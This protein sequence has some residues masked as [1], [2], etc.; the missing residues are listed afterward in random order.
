MPIN[1]TMSELEGCG[2]E[3]EDACTEASR[4]EPEATLFG[5]D[6]MNMKPLVVV[7]TQEMNWSNCQS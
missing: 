2:D 1:A 6:S 5:D 3:L 7:N 4:I